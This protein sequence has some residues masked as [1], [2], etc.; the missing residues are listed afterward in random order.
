MTRVCKHMSS[1][2]LKFI[3]FCQNSY[4]IEIVFIKILCVRGRTTLRNNRISHA[5]SRLHI[6]Q[7]NM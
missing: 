6:F 3:L 4:S 5:S 7:Y 1:M 2:K